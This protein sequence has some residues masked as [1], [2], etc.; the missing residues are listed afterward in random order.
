MW[1]RKFQV[2]WTQK[3]ISKQMLSESYYIN[4]LI[5]FLIFSGVKVYT[6]VPTLPCVGMYRSETNEIFINNPNARDA[7]ITIA[8]EAG[9]W[10]GYG[11]CKKYHSY[12]RE[13]QA[14]VYGWK[15]LQTIGATT[16]S[17]LEW[18]VWHKDIKYLPNID[19]TLFVQ[20]SKGEMK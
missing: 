17:R 13:R 2:K 7:L 4:K 5:N 1:Q 3:I 11:L 19:T 16:I 9:H 12:Q 8:H 6:F 20:P 18:I 10:F 14:F 15:I